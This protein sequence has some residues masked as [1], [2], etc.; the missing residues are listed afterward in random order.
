[1]SSRLAWVNVGGVTSVGAAT[2]TA[3]TDLVTVTGHALTDGALVAFDTLT[4]GADG[5]IE[6]GVTYYVR[7]VSGDTFQIAGA[8]GGNPIA[9][10]A[11]GTANAYTATPSYTAEELRQIASHGLFHGAS[12]R[13]GAREGVRPGAGDPVTVAAGQYQ[14]QTHT[15]VVDPGTLTAQGPYTYI[16]L[17]GNATA[18]NPADGSNDRIDALDVQVSDD[19]ADGSTG[20]GHTIVYVPGV[21][22]G[23]P[24]PPVLTVRSM[25]LATITVPAG[26]ESLAEVLD[27]APWAVASGGVLPVRDEDE[28][29]TVGTYGGMAAYQQD[30]KAL[31]L[32]DGTAW[33]TAGSTQGFQYMATVYVTSSD[34][35]TKAD[36]PG[37]RAVRVQCQAGGGGGGSAA[38]TSTGEASASGGG[39]GGEWSQKW[40]LAA[41]LAASETVTVGAGGAGGTSGGN[42]TV[43]GNTSFGSH[44]TAIGGDGGFTRGATTTYNAATGGQGGQGGVGD[45][46]IRGGGGSAGSA[47]ARGSE[48]GFHG[49][50]G[51]SML[52]R[53]S[54]G[55]RGST[56]ITGDPGSLYGG[57]GGGAVNAASASAR[58][59]AA[60]AAGIVVIDLFV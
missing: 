47:D 10:D 5:P 35:F 20:R 54:R 33:E 60:G 7:N 11:D 51:S 14:V 3:A 8:R 1:M 28:L 25:R 30:T 13:V 50:G 55:S 42:G 41:D 22:A 39:G 46:T 19:D 31:R 59:G 9:F 6:E 43:G 48:G 40:I 38:A 23:T 16:Q 18:L 36:Y 27:L 29:P 45:L 12:D 56:G 34:T 44:C 32:H 17:Q 4:L 2:I 37:L 26:N 53:E 24:S 15:G 57:G 21:P 49:V 52:G 58:A